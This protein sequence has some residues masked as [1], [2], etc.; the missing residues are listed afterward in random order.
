MPANPVA[1]PGKGVYGYRQGVSPAVSYPMPASITMFGHSYLDAY[2]GIFGG[3][4]G[5]GYID[6]SVHKQILG[7]FNL[8]EK[9]CNTRAQSGSSIITD[10]TPA[11]PNAGWVTVLQTLSPVNPRQLAGVATGQRNPWMSPQGLCLLMFGINDVVNFAGGSQDQ[12]YQKAYIEAWRTCIARCRAGAVFEEDNAIFAFSGGGL[13]G[14]HWTQIT[15]ITQNSGTGFAR[16]STVGATIGTILPIDFTGSYVDLGFIGRPGATGGQAT[17]AI[18]GTIVDRINTSNMT[19]NST[20]KNGTAVPA[21]SIGMVRRYPISGSGHVITVTITGIDGNFDF[22]YMQ[23][24]ATEPN[25]IIVSGLNKLRQ[26]AFGTGNWDNEMDNWQPLINSVA[27]EFPQPI[28]IIDMEDAIQQSIGQANFDNQRISE[29]DLTHPNELGARYVAAAVLDAWNRI[30]GLGYQLNP[31]P[32][33][34]YGSGHS[35]PAVHTTAGF[36]IYPQGLTT[37]G[38][39]FNGVAGQIVWLPLLI[40]RPCTIDTINFTN[41]TA[42]AGNMRIGLYHD[43]Q[44]CLVASGYNIG[45]F[46]EVYDWGSFAIAVAANKTYAIPAAQQKII[47]PGIYWLAILPL[48]GSTLTC[49]SLTGSHP[50]ILPTTFLNVGPSNNCGWKMGGGQTVLP[51]SVLTTTGSLTPASS[52]PLVGLQ[53]IKV[54]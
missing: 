27:A 23:L 22:D 54:P 21:T 17:I 24:E 36:H 4:P 5:L 13:G 47:T 12:L 26:Y 41:I 44:P 16:T 37:G 43:T 28:Q 6:Q 11:V 14:A 15:S 48:A 38:A 34:D 33:R 19:A 39:A 8:T 18:D 49:D 31:T 32:M 29:L 45:P 40:T 3:N 25:P 7:I 46:R 35:F 42:A 30:I 9:Q 50:Y 20:A 2:Q 1:P 53:V 51:T 52:I 10:N